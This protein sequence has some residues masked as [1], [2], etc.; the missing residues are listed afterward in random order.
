[1]TTH[2]RSCNGTSN[3]FS[4]FD[5]RDID[6][7]GDNHVSTSI[8]TPMRPDAHQLNDQDKIRIISEHMEHILHTLGMDLSDDSLQGTP[9]RVAKMYV[10]EV[11]SGLNPKNKPEVRLF[12][13]SYGYNEMLLEK[14]ISVYSYCEHHL[15]PIF[16]RA[17]VAYFPKDKVIGLSKINRLVK[18]YARRPQ[19]QERLTLQIAREFRDLLETDDVA[20]IID[21]H[22]MCVSSRGIEDTQSSTV[23]AKY[24]GRFKEHETRS[25]LLRYIGGTNQVR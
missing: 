20:V 2:N 25:E 3:G 14:D 21:S 18:Y 9:Q 16:G 7:L 13:N 4:D 17:H 10:Q 23:T 12:E 8:E 22:H 15:V 24:Y 11:F 19:V 1:M 5:L 6:E